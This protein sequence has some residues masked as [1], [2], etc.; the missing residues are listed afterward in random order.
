MQVYRF[1]LSLFVCLLPFAQAQA[2][3]WTLPA[4]TGAIYHTVSSYRTTSY[5]DAAGQKQSQPAYTKYEYN[6]VVEWGW[7]EG[8]TLGGSLALNAVRATAF[9]AGSSRLTGMNQGIADPTLYLR[10]RL[11]QHKNTLLSVQPL[12]KF[13]SYVRQRN[14]PTS[15]TMQTDAELRLLGGHS[16]SVLGMPSFVNLEAAYRKRMG[17]A[18]D[19]LRF[20]GSVGMTPFARWE[21]WQII[22]QFS[23]VR[24]LDSCHQ[25]PFTQNAEDDYDLYKTQLSAVYQLDAK[26]HLQAGIFHHSRGVNTGAGGGALLSLWMQDAW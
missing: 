1:A 9:A 7:R 11:W 8:T 10:Q 3:A 14:L 21:K 16:F 25:M 12:L 13:P 24:R 26:T 22:P 19:Q 20:D 2:S 18:G 6:P 5:F 4:N 15:G 17:E 23:L